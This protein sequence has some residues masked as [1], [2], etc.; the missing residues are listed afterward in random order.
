MKDSYLYHY[1]TI[2]AL[3]GILLG[4]PNK[5]TFLAS[6][7]SSMNDPTEVL[8]GYNILLKEKFKD[9]IKEALK[10]KLIGRSGDSLFLISFSRVPDSLSM[11]ICY[12]DGGAGVCLK[13]R[14]SFISRGMPSGTLLDVLYYDDEKK[15]RREQISPDNPSFE[16]NV[17]SFVFSC[18]CDH[19]SYEK[20]TRFCV[21]KDENDPPETKKRLRGDGIIKYV[22]VSFP[23]DAL[24]QIIVGPKASRSIVN[25]IKD[26]CGS[27]ISVNKTRLPFR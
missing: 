7:A 14:R 20:E 8:D 13:L 1:T 24:S 2:Q 10:A 19:Y 25:A 15:K 3:G 16:E 5:L 17:S 12:A 9:K 4:N 26:I 18:K 23:M 6:V 27:N 11:W 22:V 21:V